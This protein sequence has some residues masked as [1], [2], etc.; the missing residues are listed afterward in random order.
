MKISHLIITLAIFLFFNAAQRGDA[1]P[2][3]QMTRPEGKIEEYKIEPLKEQSAGRRSGVK[4]EAKES[5][6]EEIEW[7]KKGYDASSAGNYD[8]AV[9]YYKKAIAI[10]PGYADAHA[11]LGANYIQKGMFDQAILNLKK[12][13]TIDPKNAGAHYNL[14]LAYDKKS[15]IDEAISEYEK[16]IDI[17]PDF[18]KAY[19]NLGIAYFDKNK[20]SMAAE[21]FY[22]A[23]LIF[24]Q[25]D[26]IQGALR[27]YDA[28]TLTESE[29]LKH[30]LSEKLFPEQNQKDNLSSE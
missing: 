23:S 11:N 26:D 29:E 19:Q 1:K 4:E 17:N 28:L 18:A 3:K 15:M 6:G 5:L 7:F 2:N 22:K 16:T 27:A 21:C 9:E 10:N 25:Q 12:A 8:E 13:L 30:A 24:L 20:K 14:G